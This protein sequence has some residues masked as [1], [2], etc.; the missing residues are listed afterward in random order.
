MRPVLVACAAAG[1]VGCVFIAADS[2]VA[3]VHA[4]LALTGLDDFG[5]KAMVASV[6][7]QVSRYVAA[8]LVTHW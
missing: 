6:E 1:Q 8:D 3:G 4:D 2:M 5:W 7:R